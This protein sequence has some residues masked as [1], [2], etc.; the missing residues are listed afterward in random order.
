MNKEKKL[1]KLKKN[2]R[3]NIAEAIEKLGEVHSKMLKNFTDELKG[4]WIISQIECAN[5]L[6][7]D[8]FEQLQGLIKKVEIMEEKKLASI[9][10]EPNRRKEAKV[11]T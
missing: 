7:D 9:Q 8:E 11:K 5:Y 4:S 6:T 1:E 10:F 3:M 2:K